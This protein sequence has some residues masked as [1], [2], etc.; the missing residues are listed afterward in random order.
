MSIQES[1]Y[2]M[3]RATRL[4]V[5]KELSAKW[6]EGLYDH[7]RNTIQV[8]VNVFT[9]AGILDAIEN[10]AVSRDSHVQYASKKVPT[11]QSV[12]RAPV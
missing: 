8:I 7:L 10:S 3:L 12:L 11:V 9:E 5:M 2:P 6:L 4:S 1:R